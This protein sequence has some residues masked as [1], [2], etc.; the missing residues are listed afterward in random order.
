MIALSGP[1]RYNRLCIFMASAF[2]TQIF[3]LALLAALASTARA[4]QTVLLDPARGGD[5]AGASIADHATE[6]IVTLNLA[7]RIAPLLRARGFNVVLTRE[8][9]VNVSNDARAALANGSNAIACV[10]LHATGSGTGVHLWTSALKPGSMPAAVPWNAAQAPYV[11]ASQQLAEQLRDAF[12]R[13]KLTVSAGQTWVRP[14]DN[15]M[16]PAVAIEVAPEADG[17]AADDVHYQTHLAEALAG[18]LLF[19]RGHVPALPQPVA[20]PAQPSP[21]PQPSGQPAPNPAGSATGK[22]P[23]APAGARQ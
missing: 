12:S 20:P 10:V 14:L 13:S 16:C 9:D 23:S 21:S 22:A 2:K 3:G 15:M 4:Q 8:A 1:C 6:K 7:E 19:W 17:T 11:S 18:A 5:E